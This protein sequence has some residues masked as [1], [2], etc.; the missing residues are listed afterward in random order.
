MRITIDTE[1]CQGHGVC[2]TVAPELFGD[3]DRGYGEVRGDGS[4]SEDQAEAA[5]RAVDRCPERAITI[6]S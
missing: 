3:D 2:Y 5:A 6:E 4:V 1:R